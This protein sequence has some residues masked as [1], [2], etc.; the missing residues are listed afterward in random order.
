V[1][2]TWLSGV[3]SDVLSTALFVKGS[4]NAAAYAQARGLAL[5]IVDDEG[6]ALVV[7]APEGS[8]LTVAEQASPE[9]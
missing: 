5:Y 8:G 6:R 2:G 1:A 3:D 7:P 9:P 4:G